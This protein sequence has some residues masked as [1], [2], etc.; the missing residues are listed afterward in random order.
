MNSKKTRNRRRNSNSVSQSPERWIFRPPPRSHLGETHAKVACQCVRFATRCAHQLCV[1]PKVLEDGLL[2]N[3]AWVFKLFLDFTLLFIESKLRILFFLSTCKRG[4]KQTTIQIYEVCSSRNST[5]FSI[6]WRKS[7]SKY[8]HSHRRSGE[9]KIV[10]ATSP[11][12][13]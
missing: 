13:R 3:N 12:R 10:I 6:S 2:Y 11:S 5:L 8:A 7:A 4:T 9:R 1:K